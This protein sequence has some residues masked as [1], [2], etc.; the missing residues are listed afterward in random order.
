MVGNRSFKEAVKAVGQLAVFVA[1]YPL[2]FKIPVFFLY[3]TYHS[4]I[5]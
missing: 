5:L 2:E 1:E 4:G 3:S